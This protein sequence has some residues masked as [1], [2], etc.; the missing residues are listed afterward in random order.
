MAKKSMIIKAARTPK[1]STRL[2]H[3]CQICGRPR[4]YLRKYKMCRLCF[5]KLASEGLLPGVT[6]SSW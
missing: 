6:K 5:R 4:G 1:Y 2:V 3:R